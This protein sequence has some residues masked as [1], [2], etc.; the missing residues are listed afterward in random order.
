MKYGFANHHNEQ[1]AQLLRVRVSQYAPPRED[2]S[3]P[4]MTDSM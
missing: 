4:S 3:R 2:T 1:D